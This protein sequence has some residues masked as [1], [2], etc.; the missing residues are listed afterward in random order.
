M[1]KEEDK[2]NILGDIVWKRQKNKDRHEG[3]NGIGFRAGEYFPY[4]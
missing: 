3:V 1:C 2:V 4:T